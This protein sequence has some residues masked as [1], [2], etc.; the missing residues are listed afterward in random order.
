MKPDVDLHDAVQLEE[1]ELY[2][3]LVIA[4]SGHEGPLTVAEL[5]TLLGVAPRQ[6]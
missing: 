1:I 4:A 2:G 6:G 5:D 3:S